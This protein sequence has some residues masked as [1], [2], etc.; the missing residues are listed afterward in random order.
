M[1]LKE[2]DHLTVTCGRKLTMHEAYRGVVRGGSV[3]L[4]QKDNPLTEGT[5]VLVTPVVDRPGSA[6]AVLAA[7]TISPQ[8]PSEWV[9]ELEHII[10]Q[11]QRPPMRRDPFPDELGSQEGQ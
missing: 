10:A 5:E 11:G 9:D 2:H 1:H 3:V 8:V 6:A 7:V 4:L